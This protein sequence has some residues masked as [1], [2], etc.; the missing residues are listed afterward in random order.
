MDELR[1]LIM[2]YDNLYIGFTLAIDHL[3]RKKNTRSPSFDKEQKIQNKIEKI[4]E[5]IKTM[6]SI[7]SVKAKATFSQIIV[8]HKTNSKIKLKGNSTGTLFN[9]KKVTEKIKSFKQRKSQEQF[10]AKSKERFEEDVTKYSGS[11]EEL[12]EFKKENVHLKKVIWE[13]SKRLKEGLNLMKIQEMHPSQKELGEEGEEKQEREGDILQKEINLEYIP[14]L[15]KEQKAMISMKILNLNLQNFKKSDKMRIV[16]K[17]DEIKEIP[18]LFIWFIDFI[19]TK[20]KKLL[21]RI[22]SIK[23]EKGKRMKII[24]E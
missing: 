23:S 12:K 17:L 4:K 19:K 18:N 15:L 22:E 3:R 8:D 24:F 5:N 2:S 13:Y 14:N 6:N 21:K 1:N 11:F 20:M 16:D 7:P 9:H 10:F